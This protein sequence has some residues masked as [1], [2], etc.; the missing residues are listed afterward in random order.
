MSEQTTIR[1][2]KSTLK[3]LRG[4]KAHPRATDEE[5]LVWLLDQHEEKEVS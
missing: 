4:Y 5:V 2:N 3:R 1:V